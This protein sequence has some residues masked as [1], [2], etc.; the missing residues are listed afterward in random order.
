MPTHS[1]IT[2]E[3][4]A[5]ERDLGSSDTSTMQASFPSSPIHFTPAN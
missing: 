4:V 2:V 1:Q 3:A 5:T